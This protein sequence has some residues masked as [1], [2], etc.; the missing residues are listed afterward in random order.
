MTLKFYPAGFSTLP[1]NRQHFSAGLVDTFV[2][3][4][5]FARAGSKPVP[6]GCTAFCAFF[7]FCTT[8]NAEKFKTAPSVFAAFA[9]IRTRVTAHCLLLLVEN[10]L[11]HDTTLA[12]GTYNLYYSLHASSNVA[13]IQYVEYAKQKKVAYGGNDSA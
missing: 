6:T 2:F 9:T 13:I 11:Q 12:H 7:V 5:S 3:I 10:H 4:S 1:A 8:G